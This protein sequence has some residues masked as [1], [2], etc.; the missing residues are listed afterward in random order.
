MLL[1]PSDV[2]ADTVC[3][4]DGCSNSLA[5][6][7]R[8]Y[9]LYSSNV[10]NIFGNDTNYSKC[11]IGG[12]KFGLLAGDF[13]RDGISDVVRAAAST[14]YVYDRNC[15]LIDT[16]QLGSDFLQAM[17][18]L[19]NH[20]SDSYPNLILLTNE[21]LTSWEYDPDIGNFYERMSFDLDDNIGLSDFDLFTCPR[22]FNLTYCMLFRSKDIFVINM[23]NGTQYY[24][25]SN[26][27]TYNAH[28]NTIRNG[29]TSVNCNDG[30]IRIPMCSE[31]QVDSE[32][33]CFFVDRHG[34][35]TSSEI[36]II[37]AESH[38]IDSFEYH[39]GTIAKSENQEMLFVHSK[40][41]KSGNWQH[42]SKVFDLDGTLLHEAMLSGARTTDNVTSN[43]VIADV[44]KDGASDICYLI[45]DTAAY[46]DTPINQIYLQCY[47]PFMTTVTA[48]FM[49]IGVGN[50]SKLNMTNSIAMGDFVPA[51][52]LLSFA[53]VEGLFYFDGSE[54]V[55]L[56]D[57][58][59]KVGSERNGTS[60]IYDISGSGSPVYAYSDN[61]VGFI[62]RNVALDP[63]CGNGVCNEFE[64][65]FS[66]PEDC[67]V[68]ATGTVNQSG[69]FCLTDAD[70][71]Y[72]VCEYGFC[73]LA[74]ARAECNVDADCLSGVCSNGICT[75]PSYWKRIDASKDQQYGDDTN[76]N[77]F[78]ALFFMILIPAGIIWLGRSAIAIFG[79]IG[80]FIVLSV[81][82]LIVGYLSAFIFIGIVLVMLLIIVFAFML[83]S[84]SD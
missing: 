5:T 38:N 15:G 25:K 14:V 64:N 21:A 35:E 60:I 19:F 59:Y 65:S 22:D 40:F 41:K 26:E 72:G 30:E 39:L 81:F 27:L 2:K 43:F 1:I 54:Y 34:N 73:I 3:Y 7:G 17:P 12:S 83:G 46:P 16:I 63:L 45:N 20:D 44:N 49:L 79:A 53:T 48:E 6:G 70:C 28:Y 61:A 24:N 77:N 78:I 58:G 71:Q 66:C 80:A 74:G 9:T 11:D 51:S 31:N 56:L 62:I 69:D 47:D 37:D 4:Y 82:F 75:I 10:K 33:S 67:G 32:I 57:T 8:G 18:V 55:K 84:S 36:K 23:S 13:D 50:N 42:V 52:G 76:T 29:I 68:N